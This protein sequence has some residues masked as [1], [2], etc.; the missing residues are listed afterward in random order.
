MPIAVVKL[1]S[2]IV[3][4][5]N[6]ELRLSVVARICEE[7]AALHHEG[8]DVVVVTSGAIARGMRLL[9]HGH[10]PG[11]GPGPAG[12]QRRRPGPPLPDLRRAAARAR[13][14]ERPGAA[15]LLRRQ[16]PHA[17]PQR[18]P[19]AGAAARVADRA[20]HQRERHDDDRRDV[21]RR[22]RLPGRAGVRAR[23]RRPARPAD[24]HRGALHRGPAQVGGRASSC[25]TSPTPSARRAPDRPRAVAARLGRDALE[26]RGGRDGVGR[27]DRDG[28]RQRARRRACWR[29]PGPA[30][31]PARASRRRPPASRASSCGSSTPSPATAR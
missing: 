1:G 17:L 14:P 28:D 21:V 12:G 20:G 15:H 23:G 26:G 10:A 18:A 6:G 5:D 16:R 22:Q 7:V 30:S 9:G 29:A 31:R 25:R 4:E 11:L 27:R 3:A 24:R 19:D 8:V 2:S 13:D